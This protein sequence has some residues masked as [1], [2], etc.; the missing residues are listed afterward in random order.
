MGC[1][2][3]AIIAAFAP[4]IALVLVWIFTPYVSRA[5]GSF[6]WPLLGL[7]FLPFTTLLY[8]LVYQPGV[9]V[10]GWGWFWVAL[11]L[12]LDI[13]SYSGGYRGRRSYR[14]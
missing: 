5:Y 9:G 14:D 11:G 10:T 2:L 3:I 1:C 12:F 6:L 8:A 4:R 13:S 7:L